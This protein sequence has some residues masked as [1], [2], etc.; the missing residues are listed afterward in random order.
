AGG[1]DGHHGSTRAEPQRERA[2][3]P[4]VERGRGPARAPITRQR[5]L[6]LLHAAERRAQDDTDALGRR[7]EA[8]AREQVVGRGEEE[9]GRSA[10]FPLQALELLDLA[11]P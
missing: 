10:A 2:R 4:V 11:A 3:G 1:G 8:S 5:A 9:L 6:A 7:I